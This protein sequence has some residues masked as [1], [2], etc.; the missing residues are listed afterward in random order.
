MLNLIFYVLIG[1]TFGWSFHQ[2]RQGTG[3]N[4]YL[5]MFFG[6]LGSISI[7]YASI[8]ANV[9]LFEGIGQILIF[10]TFG[11]IIFILAAGFL[12]NPANRFI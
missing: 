6:A 3:I 9:K 10:S 4:V 8:W 12:K 7:N 11:A 5:K 1:I 2:F